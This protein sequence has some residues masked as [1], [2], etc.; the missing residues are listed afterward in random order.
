MSS[1]L[2]CDSTLAHSYFE[3]CCLVFRRSSSGPTAIVRRGLSIFS[4]SYPMCR[5][6]WAGQDLQGHRMKKVTQEKETIN[7]YFLYSLYVRYWLGPGW[8][9]QQCSLQSAVT[10]TVLPNVRQ[11][12]RALWTMKSP[13]IAMMLCCNDPEDAVPGDS[14]TVRGIRN[15]T[16]V[17]T[18]FYEKWWYTES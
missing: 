6:G 5:I 13:L 17:P 7:Q 3:V 15:Q 9:T 16:Q 10:R 11:L 4:A 14:S 18:D 12:R 2:S 8:N 1:N